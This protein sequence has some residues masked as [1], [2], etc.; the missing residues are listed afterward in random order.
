MLYVAVFV[1][2]YLDLFW[3]PPS[4]SFYLFI[5]KNIYIWTSIYIIILMTR[6]FART[7]ER[8]KAWKLG[9]IAALGSLLAAP[10][11]CLIFRGSRGTT[12]SEVRRQSCTSEVRLMYFV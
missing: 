3:V 9:S 10:L 7:R 8:E 1:S 6:I 2:R 12:F 5:M 4:R 11:V